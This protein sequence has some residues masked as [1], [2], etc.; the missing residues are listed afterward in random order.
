MCTRKT[1]GCGPTFDT[2]M[3]IEIKGYAFLVLKFSVTFNVKIIQFG[4]CQIKYFKM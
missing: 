4:I 3:C 2:Q 1:P